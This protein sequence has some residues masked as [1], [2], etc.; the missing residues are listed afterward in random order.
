[1]Y[2]HSPEF[3]QIADQAAAYA[4]PLILQTIRD[5]IP[6][7]WAKFPAF[8]SINCSTGKILW[9][10]GTAS[11]RTQLD[12]RKSPLLL[13]LKDITEKDVLGFCADITLQPALL[14]D[15]VP[16]EEAIQDAEA[17]AMSKRFLFDNR[18]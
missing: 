8:T 7:F 16:I 18:D 6:D 4:R 1:M 14:V 15:G 10:F 2:Y 12:A 9:H 11:M 5:L 3:Q 17:Y 13:F